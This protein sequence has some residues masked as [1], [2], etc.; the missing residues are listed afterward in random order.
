MKKTDAEMFASILFDNPVKESKLR[1]LNLA[2]NMFGKEGF[3]TLT[4]ALEG[5][6]S[7]QNLDL[8]RCNLG[9]SGFAA[10]STALAKNKTLKSLNL[11]GNNGD[12]DGARALRSSLL[13][14]TS[15]EFLDLGYNRLREK[16]CRAITEGF[17]ENKNSAL[18]SI[19]LRY[20]FINDDGIKNFFEKAI[21]K[22]S[23]IQ[24]AF[25]L[26]NYLHEHVTHELYKKT[27]EIG[28]KVY[29][30]EFVKIQNMSSEK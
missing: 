21:F 22:S 29:V 3:K 26:Q 5:N 28:R 7:L 14:N 18:N 11:F 2:R 10:I 8:S 16:G 1:S 23:K 17:T 20:N 27:V 19:A 25:I 9:V 30:D 24:Q 13:V 6:K 4:V 15:L 12:V